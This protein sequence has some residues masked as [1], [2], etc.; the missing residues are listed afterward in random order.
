[1]SLKLFALRPACL[2][3]CSK[4]ARNE[5]DRQAHAHMH[6]EQSL[7]T[8]RGVQAGLGEGDGDLEDEHRGVALVAGVAHA[9]ADRRRPPAVFAYSYIVTLLLVVNMVIKNFSPL[10]S[11][12]HMSTS[13]YFFYTVYYVKHNC[14]V[15]HF[16]DKGAVS[17]GLGLWVI[18][19]PMSHIAN[20]KSTR[21]AIELCMR[22]ATG[23]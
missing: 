22:A 9:R 20:V 5:A 12:S 14:R 1:M 6:V 16:D 7:H 17:S 11:L 19:H 2:R 13:R 15:V 18:L 4:Q 8:W 3:L 23:R 21:H 10:I